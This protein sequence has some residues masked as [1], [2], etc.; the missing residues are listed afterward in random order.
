MASDAPAKD[1]GESLDLTDSAIGVEQPL[2]EGI[3]GDATTEDELS[4]NS[5]WAKNSR[6]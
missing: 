1:Q 2:L 5:T 6:R 3:D 4:Q